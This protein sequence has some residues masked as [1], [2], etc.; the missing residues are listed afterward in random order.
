M[1][2]E[3]VRHTIVPLNQISQ[4]QFYYRLS[5]LLFASALISPEQADKLKWGMPYVAVIMVPPF[6][7][8]EIGIH[9]VSQWRSHPLVVHLNQHAVKLRSM[10]VIKYIKGAL[11]EYGN[12]VW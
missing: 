11:M 1:I 6:R 5:V 7:S 8:L 9:L 2:Y 4:K 3:E 12:N 10:K